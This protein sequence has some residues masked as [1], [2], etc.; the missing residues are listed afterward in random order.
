M[1]EIVIDGVT[2]VPKNEVTLKKASTLKGKEFCVI[3]TYSAGVFAGYYDRKTK[4]KEATIENAI[5]V[6]Y[7]KGANS[8][9]DLATKGS[10]APS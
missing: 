4:G 2:Y 10:T 6:W 1:K 5:R 7:W 8:L 3:R 9:S